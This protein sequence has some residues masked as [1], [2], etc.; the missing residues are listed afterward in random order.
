[1]IGIN[2]INETIIGSKKNIVKVGYVVPNSPAERSGLFINDI[3]LKVGQKNIQNSSDVVNAITDNGTNKS[4]N[5]TIKRKNKIMIL[6][7]KPTDIKNLAT[8]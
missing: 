8:K 2:L 5:I 6:R 1:M 3:I 7:V 4:I